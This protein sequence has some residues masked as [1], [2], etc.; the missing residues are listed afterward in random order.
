[1]KLPDFK[2]SSQLNDLRFRMKADLV[3]F[4]S[5]MDW[6]SISF[7]EL[8]QLRTDGVEVPIEEL[9]FLPDGTFIWKNQRVIVY[10]RDQIGY[11]RDKGYKFHLCDCTT[12][13]GM[14]ERGR[15]KRYVLSTR[16][17]GQ[18]L[19]NVVG[20]SGDIIERDIIEPLTVCKNCLKHLDYKGYKTGL[21]SKKKKVYENFSI[22]RF[23]DEFGSKISQKP[24][25]TDTT[26]P[27]NVYPSNWAE[28][29]SKAKTECG[30]RCTRCKLDMTHYKKYFHTHHRDGIK[31][32]N[33]IGNLVPLCVECHGRIHEPDGNGANMSSQRSAFRH[34]LRIR[35]DL[36][37]T[38]IKWESAD[39]KVFVSSEE[40][41]DIPF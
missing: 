26:A 16:T 41:D 39:E 40:S 21:S 2:E 6:T 13:Q 25:H 1:M 22:E 29:S 5:N 36:T 24:I 19:I 9:E 10:I 18:F 31:S 35:G 14:R 20:K 12:I 37:N 28:L 8:N 33:W 27:L 7:A 17:D 34:A 3:E 15:Y 32:N 30:W 11:Y 4:N 38:M 23:F